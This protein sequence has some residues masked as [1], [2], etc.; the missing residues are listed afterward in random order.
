[1]AYTQYEEQTSCLN[2]ND[3]NYNKVDHAFIMNMQSE[4]VTRTS[5]STA[6]TNLTFIRSFGWIATFG[7]LNDGSLTA[8]SSVS[9]RSVPLLNGGQLMAVMQ[10]G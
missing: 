8:T 4:H 9:R 1:M 2:I 6:A 5:T 10:T 3:S 7:R